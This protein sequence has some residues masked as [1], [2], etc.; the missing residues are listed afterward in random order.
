MSSVHSEMQNCRN[1]LA[2]V[3]GE[4]CAAC[5]Q[6][7]FNRNAFRLKG[8]LKEAIEEAFDYDSKVFATMRLLIF[9]PGELTLYYL[10]GK[11]KTYFN[12]IKLYLAVI[13]FNFLV[14]STMDN[15]SPINIAYLMNMG[16]PEWFK[17]LYFQKQA[18]SGLE[19][20]FFLHKVN[21]QANNVFSFALYFMIFIFPLALMGWFYR[22]EKF[23]IE[24]MVFCLHFM[25]FGFL[26][27]TVFLPVHMYNKD[28]G[29]V[30]SIVTT[31]VYLYYA[32]KKVYGG[33]KMMQW[34]SPLVL[35]TFFLIMFTCTIVFS[36]TFTILIY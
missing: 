11:Q 27:D 22:S 35:Y 9:K 17:E 18:S 3:S 13:A 5:G 16:A 10:H 19:K 26:R 21:G 28:L 29:F 23:Y 24:H 32:L 34:V 12:P 33:N 2:L 6:K 25:A 1:C 20:D 30:L 15:Y 8:F 31:V 36:F 14:Y 7:K 4:Y